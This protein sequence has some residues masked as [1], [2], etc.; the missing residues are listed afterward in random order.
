MFTIENFN[1][2]Q[3]IK[4][5]ESPFVSIYIPTYRAGNNQEDKLRL[6]NALSK[7]VSQLTDEQLFPDKAM[8]KHD[9]QKYL[10]AA[11][12]LIEDEQFWLELSDGLAIFLSN[13][14]FEH[15]IVPIDFQS[16]VYVGNQ[17]YLRQLFPVL[18]NDDKFFILA[19][20]QNGIR[21]FEARR[22]SIAP[23]KIKDLVPNAMNEL[24]GVD[25]SKST[26]QAHSGGSGDMIFHGHSSEN[27]DY[28]KKYFR[29]IDDG[30][31]TML[32]DENAPMVI[33]SVDYQIPIYK[34]ISKYSNVADFSIKG[35]PENDDPIL[36]HEKAWAGMKNYFSRNLE[37]AK[38]VFNEALANNKAS[39]SIQD[40]VPA[41][42]NGKVETL[43]VDSKIDEVW[44]IY[45]K[46]NNTVSIHK[47]RRPDSN[48]L[49]QDAAI[50]T[51]NNGGMV[52]NIPRTEFPRIFTQLNAIYRY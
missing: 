35:N 46:S 32:H 48:C 24:I 20:S 2:L 38:T 27:N 11:Y 47:N 21:F 45:N 37:R 50:A 4:K 15:Y 39:F 10:S 7:A 5:K 18:I 23:V 17:F 14:Q 28:L 34:E 1:A 44:G 41:S 16:F 25:V 36:I 19:L 22:N 6:K 52:Y 3:N 42:M 9:A 12:A 33:Y 31:M 40:I 29:V 49:L 43:F 8:E 30:L 26:L 51:F 13:D